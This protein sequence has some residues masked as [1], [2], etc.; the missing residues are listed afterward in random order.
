MAK[1]G[2]EKET[3]LMKQYNALKAKYPNSLLLFRVGDFY[4]TFGGDAEVA[5]SILNITLT[6]RS[7]GAASEVALAGF[8]H[9]ALDNYLPKL[10][11]AGQRVAVCD[12]LEDPKLVAAGQIVKRG[13]TELVTPGV[14][15]SDN[16]LEACKNNYLCAIYK[17]GSLW[18]LAFLDISTGTFEL[19]EGNNHQA[20][21]LV[22]AYQPNEIVFARGQKNEVKDLLGS[23]WNYY[24]MEDWLFGYDFGFDLLTRHFQTQ[25]LKGFGVEDFT[26]GTAS[27]GAILQYLKDTEHHNLGHLTGIR[28]VDQDRYVW[29]DSFTI[30]NLELVVPSQEK[31][32]PLVQVLDATHTPM[33]ARLLRHWILMPLKELS[34]IKERLHTVEGI[35]LASEDWRHKLV[36]E[37]KQTGDLERLIARIAARKTNP[38]DLNQLRKSLERVP[39]IK[40][41]LKELGVE[42]LNH[43]ADRLDPCDSLKSKIA[44]TLKEDAP[45]ITHQGGLIKEGIDSKIDELLGL[46]TLGKDFIQ[47]IQEKEAA[48]TQIPSLKINFNKVFGYYLEVTNAHKNKVPADWI[49][50]QTLVNAERYITPELKVWEEKVLNAESELFALEQEQFLRLA[51]FTANYAIV[52]QENARLLARLDCLLGFALTSIQY[53]YT[54][55]EVHDGLS[56][57]IKEGRHPV[58]ERQLPLGESYIPNDVLVDSQGDQILVITGPNMSGKSAVLR[59]AALIVLMAQMGCFVPAKAASIGLVDKIFTRVGASDNLSQGESTFMVEMSE[60]ASILNNLSNRSLILMDEIGRGT[61]TYD[62]VSIAWAIVEYLHRHPLFKA[63]TLFATHYHELNEL[64]AKLP[65]I[66]NYNVAVK[67][68]GNTILFLRKLQKGGS[69]HSF[70]IHVAQMAG[71]PNSVVLRANEILQTLEE[72]SEKRRKAEK[73]KEVQKQAGYQMSFFSPANPI[74][75]K[76]KQELEML[77]IDGLTPVQALLKLADLKKLLF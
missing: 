30:R 7:N 54:K 3:P 1:S 71:M 77:D 41:L 70:G 24:L 44:Q 75:E 34:E 48:N 39:H 43:L 5:A 61:A 66:V 13:V 73:I 18:G 17:L 23:D 53:Q 37:L 27:A 15:L 69:N 28:R 58:I 6:K 32:V 14:A 50:K 74:T 10:V 29:M 19:S 67:E 4:E 59:Q 57:E 64:E 36:N 9:H 68:S 16:I 52:I 8:P 31:G 60:T 21:K 51:E 46:S 12:Q 42:S 45:A 72:G 47:A 63:K 26:A 65:G 49:R 55:P 35:T 2:S 56:L 76:I 22:N 62:G 38:R 40:S 33:G 25:H 20:K 11:R